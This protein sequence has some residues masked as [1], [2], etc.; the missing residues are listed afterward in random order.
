M[1]RL[2][3]MRQLITEKTGCAAGGVL[4]CS[5]GSW[6]NFNAVAEGGVRYVALFITRGPFINGI[7]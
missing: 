1:N 5:R 3:V 6:K 7:V 4:K 2:I